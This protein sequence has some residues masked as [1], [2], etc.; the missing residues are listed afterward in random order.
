MTFRIRSALACFALPALLCT[1]N[2]AAADQRAAS[3]NDLKANPGAMSAVMLVR[4]NGLSL[5]TL[6]AN[7][8][9]K[10]I[11]DNDRIAMLH[12]PEFRA[13]H[14]KGNVTEY[15]LLRPNLG[16]L[17]DSMQ[18]G[19]CNIVVESAPNIAA[20]LNEIEQD[21]LIVSILPA[22]LQ[23]A[24]LADAYAIFLGFKD[25]AELLL[26]SHMLASHEELQ[27]YYKLGVDS[28]EAYDEALS[29]MRAEGYSRDP[30][31]LLVFLKDEAE[32]L[33]RNLPA[34]VIREE[35]TAQ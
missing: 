18:G 29:R 35:R 16:V 10:F 12:A 23:P 25:N 7:V 2:L 27:A 21:G 17:Y 15:T 6:G 9:G 22:P 20:L 24:Q 19:T 11:A 28:K 8:N 14:G 33:R 30:L 5:C 32:G 34:S 13:W 26:A 3:L 4:G 1:T 31:E